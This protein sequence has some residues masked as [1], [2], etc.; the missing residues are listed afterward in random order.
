M[1]SVFIFIDP[2][3]RHLAAMA[4]SIFMGGLWLVEKHE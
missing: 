1:Q 4:I 2:K 3:H